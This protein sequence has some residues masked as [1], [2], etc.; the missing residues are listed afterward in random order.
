MLKWNDPRPFILTTCEGIVRG[1]A[2]DIERG[3]VEES[4]KPKSGR[5]GK[6]RTASAPG[7]AFASQ[8]EHYVKNIDIEVSKDS[9]K[10][11]A[12]VGVKNTPYAVRLETTMNRP[13][14]LPQARK[15]I[16]NYRRRARNR[17]RR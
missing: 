3:V 10:V 7:E 16:S 6:K 12:Y 14:W 15:A 8:S 13:V 1:I 4:F 17:R 11:V 9:T 5:Q 2:Q